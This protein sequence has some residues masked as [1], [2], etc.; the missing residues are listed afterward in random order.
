MVD[1]TL[2][3]CTGFTSRSQ[4]DQFLE[5]LE[6]PE[7]ADRVEKH[8]VDVA[9]GVLVSEKQINGDAVRVGIADRFP[10]HQLIR[11]LWVDQFAHPCIENSLHFCMQG[12]SSFLC[13]GFPWLNR[14]RPGNLVQLNPGNSMDWVG[15]QDARGLLMMGY[16]PIIQLPILAASDPSFLSICNNYPIGTR[17]IAD[18]SRGKGVEIDPDHCL[19][20]RAINLV[21]N[22]RHVTIAGGIGPDTRPIDLARILIQLPAGSQKL[23]GF[24]AESKLR[25]DCE[26][27]IPHCVN[28]IRVVLRAL[29]LVE[30]RCKSN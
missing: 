11:E 6:K 8:L 30:G 16:T 3:T 17:F 13:P 22:G 18:W 20:D 1:R 19:F 26:I 12:V 25:K 4:V 15:S 21:N 5:E 2:I 29:E 24:D 23:W 28:Y 7:I 14:L 10:D 9:V 27:H